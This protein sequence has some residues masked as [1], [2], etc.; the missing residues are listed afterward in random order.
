MN[1]FFA[2]T[3]SY[4]TIV[5]TALLCIAFFYWV[6]VIVGALGIDALDIDVDADGA[7]EGVAEGAAEGVAEGA[8]EGVAEGAAEG[9]AQG[10][11]EGAAEGAGEGASE[12]A[13]HGLLGGVVHT[14]KLRNAPMTLV[15]SLTFLFGW[16]IS[17]AASTA[18]GPMLAP[19]PTWLTGTG[20][21]IASFAGALPITSVVVRPLGRVLKV[22]RQTT[23]GDIIGSVVT[24]DTSR[25]DG[26]FGTAKAIVDGGPLLIQ[27]RSDGENQLTRG[28]QALVLSYDEARNAY[29]VTPV[30]DLLP[31][32][33]KR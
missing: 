28:A 30:D 32:Q 23:R 11:A 17:H 15:L 19:M 9:A 22:E 14:L 25:V 24:I 4:P 20:I 26:K 33:V 8:A 6:M 3:F 31:S 16:I 10:V 1:E 29:E 12:G 27:V 7:A 2:V 13:G 18:L 21:M 5:F